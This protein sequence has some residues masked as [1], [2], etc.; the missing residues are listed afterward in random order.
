MVFSEKEKKLILNSIN[1]YLE[2]L[3]FVLKNSSTYN[4]DDLTISL[5]KDYCDNLVNLRS[6]ISLIEI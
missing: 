4:I 1:V 5:L 2:N 6:K 3:D